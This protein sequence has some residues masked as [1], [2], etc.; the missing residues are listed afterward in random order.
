MRTT[1][2]LMVLFAIGLAGAFFAGSGFNGLVQGDGGTQQVSDVVNNSADG[3]VVG[4]SES[5]TGSRETTGDGSIVGLVIGGGRV[6]GSVIGKIVLLPFTL[7]Q[8]GFPAWFALP[9]GAFSE[10]VVSV[11]LIQFITGRVLR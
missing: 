5:L 2:P 1:Y 4:D 8:L 11:G 7:M 6:I 3:S 9:V 10:L